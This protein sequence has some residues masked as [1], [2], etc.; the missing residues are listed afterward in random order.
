[1]AV[2]EDDSRVRRSL[3]TILAGSGVYR[4]AG[5]YPTGEEAVA[6][7]A[8]KP[9]EVVLVDINLPAMN[10]VECV[11]QLAR[12]PAPMQM[13]MLTVNEDT[14]TIFEALQ[15]GASGYLLKPVRAQEL[16]SALKYTLEGGTPMTSS[17]ARKLVQTFQRKLA[18][19]AEA[20]SPREA[21]VLRFLAKGYSYKQIADAL[22]IGYGSV[23]TYIARI[24]KK[25]HVRSV[26]QAVAR[27]LGG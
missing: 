6:G 9:A 8:R 17:I 13:I 11:R 4:C 14:D 22:G 26:A 21:E 2:V 18:T 5:D 19:E 1:V 15:A 10:G 25:P 27:H 24:Y 23:H 12:L 16:I 20:L 3:M 7:L